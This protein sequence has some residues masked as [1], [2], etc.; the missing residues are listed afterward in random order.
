MTSDPRE[1]VHDVIVVGA[2]PAGSALAIELAR[3][4]AAV[5]LVDAARFPRDKVCGD[6]VSPRGLHRLDAL[7]CGDAVR[8]AGCVP[9]RRSRLYLNRDKLVEGALPKLPGLPDHGLAIPRLELDEILYRRALAAGARSLE[10]CRVSR[11]DITAHGVEVH[12]AHEG[13]PL[14]LRSRLLVGADG[15]TS[16]VARTRGVRLR[17]PRYTLASIRAYVRGLTLDHTLMFFDEGFFPGYGWIFPVRDGLCNAGVGMLSEP[18]V[19]D[20]LRLGDFFEKFK[21]FVAHLARARGVDVT[22]EPQRAWPIHSFGGAGR[23]HFDRGLLVGEAACFVDPI[24]GEGIPLAL[25]S[26]RLAAAT[27]REC[28]RRGR[29]GAEDL[30]GYDHAWRGAF[31]PDLAVSDLA[32]TLLRNRRL[33]P[34]WLSMFRAT[35]LTARKDPRYAEVAGGVLGGVVPARRA[36]TPEMFVRSLVHGPGFW[37]EV[38]QLDA[39]RAPGDWLARGAETARWSAAL[40]RAVRDDPAWFRDWIAEVE[41]KQRAVLARAAREALPSL[42]W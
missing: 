19:R 1:G 4:G 34:L 21:R 33:L 23:N 9:I 3:E 11:F 32:V 12:A 41:R 36:I 8:A 5:L 42:P 13:R 40:G 10:A 18:L 24:N 20:G 15:A 14:R 2:G 38:L 39:L 31:E 25:E 7:G 6:F 37:R 30:A 22:F 16:A 17:D 35:S 26:A 28:L 27:L 29:F